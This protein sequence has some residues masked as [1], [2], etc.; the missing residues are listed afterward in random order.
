MSNIVEIKRILVVRNDT[1]TKWEKSNYILEKGEIGVAWYDK[2]PITKTGNGVDTWSNLPQ[3]DYVLTSDQMLTYS[4]GR[5][6]TDESGSVNAGG[7]GMLFSEWVLDA[8]KA[9]M[10]PKITKPG[11]VSF[12]V[13]SMGTD[14]G[15]HEIGSIVN[16]IV[17][18]AATY[19][20][21]YE[22][23]TMEDRNNKIPEVDNMYTISFN[24]QP[25]HEDSVLNN[26]PKSVNPNFYIAEETSVI[27]GVL[28]FSYSWGDSKNT[29]VT[30]LG[31]K[32]LYKVQNGSETKNIELK[33]DG[34]R[35]GCFFGAIQNEVTQDSIRGLDKTGGNYISGKTYRFT[36]LPGTNKIVI[37]YDARYS[38]PISILNTT[39]NAEMLNSFEV[40][41]L[42]IS[43]ANNYE[44]IT[45]KV[46]TY[47]PAAPYKNSANIEFTLG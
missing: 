39:V 3:N 11:V 15:N 10:Q 13:L 44:P 2:T 47:I 46:L 16:Q 18:E 25:L 5:H 40:S 43:G 34:Y 1:S 24:D 42:N 36:I 33:I 6:K 14:T 7:K 12:K 17:W 20:G 27:C 45:Y 9:E 28:K 22:F 31:N 8:L 19:Q 21:E 30:N 23:G 29:P 26:I 32:A 38:G 37:A 35:E 4:F 41:E